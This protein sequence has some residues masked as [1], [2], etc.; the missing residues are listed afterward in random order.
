[1]KNNIPMKNIFSKTTAEKRTQNGVK[2]DSK[3]TNYGIRILIFAFLTLGFGQAWGAVGFESSDCGIKYSHN[4][5]SDTEWNF[6]GQSAQTKTL[7]GNTS[8]LWL[9]QWFSKMYQNEDGTIYGQ[10]YHKFV[11][12]IHRTAASAG[13]IG[14]TTLDANW[15]DWGNWDGGGYR[16]PKGGH[17]NENINLLDGLGSGKYTMTFYFQHNGNSTYKSTQNTLKWTYNIV[18]DVSRQV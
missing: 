17:N 7:T 1:M 14:F 5:G 4:G 8:S 3:R 6:N 11:Y 15:W 9:K 2:T 16:R 10:D 13:T 12:K 18:P